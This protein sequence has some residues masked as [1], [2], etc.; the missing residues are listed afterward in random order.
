MAFSENLQEL[1]KRKDM[2][3]E[4]LAEKLEVSRQ[5]VSKWESGTSYPEMEKILQ[6]CEMF[7]CN[8]GVLMQGDVGKEYV[9][10]KANYDAHKNWFSKMAAAAMAIILFCISIGML[11]A[12]PDRVTQL[13]MFSG[14]I[15]G[16]MFF[17]VAGMQS[18]RFAKKNPYIEDFYTEEEKDNFEKKFIIYCV[19]AI[20][21]IFLGVLW[22]MLSG[23]ILPREG[24]GADMDI[25]VF[26]MILSIAIPLLIYAGTQ[27]EKYNIAGYNHE[28]SQDKEKK[29]KDALVGKICAC[30]MLLAT[31]LFLGLGFTTRLW[32]MAAPIYAIGG[33]LCGVVAV[34]FSKEKK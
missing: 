3:Q 17:I 26:M 23:D 8:I 31:A 22:V 15:I 29:E 25:V 11:S 20:G 9:E 30:I 19:I 2:T 27:K 32:Y 7:R 1:R 5:S 28:N 21:M 18:E 6:I 4:Q 16:V 10:D 24:I 34:I 12:V 14:I 33:L 13:I